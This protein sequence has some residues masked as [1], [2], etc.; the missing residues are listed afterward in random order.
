MIYSVMYYIRKSAAAVV[1][2][3]TNHDLGMSP[4]FPSMS[5]GACVW[6]EP[7]AGS[8]RKWTVL[9]VKSIRHNDELYSTIVSKYRITRWRVIYTGE[10]PGGHWFK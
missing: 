4:A 7:P 6:V 10:V 3:R 2:C 9:V 1:P 5:Q 8:A